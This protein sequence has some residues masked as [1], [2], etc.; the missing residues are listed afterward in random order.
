MAEAN[1]SPVDARI[2]S[3]NVP[4]DEWEVLYRQRLQVERGLRRAAASGGGSRDG[5]GGPLQVIGDAIG[6]LVN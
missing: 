6:R 4:Y 1:F 5:K 3:L 2:A